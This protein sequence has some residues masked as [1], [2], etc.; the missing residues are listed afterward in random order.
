METRAIG[1]KCDYVK[2]DKIT[3][4]YYGGGDVH[5]AYRVKTR[6]VTGSWL[7]D[8]CVKIDGGDFPVR[9]EFVISC[10]LKGAA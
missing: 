5:S 3:F 2:G 7:G 6:V 8:P 10:D 4:K 1:K 9:S